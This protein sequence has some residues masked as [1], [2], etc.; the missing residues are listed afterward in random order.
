MAKKL[1]KEE[2]EEKIEQGFLRVRTVIEMLGAP[3]DYLT[4][5]LR[6]YMKKI[7]QNKDIILLKEKYAKPK[8]QEEMFSTFVEVDMLVRNASTLAFFCFDYMPASIEIT[9]PEKFTYNAVDFAAF[10][11]DML[12]RLHKLDMV[13]KNLNAKTENLEKNAGLLLRN[14]LLILMKEED[15]SL[16]EL[17]KGSGIPPDQLER[18]LEKLIREGWIKEKKDKYTRKK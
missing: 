8:K 11:N 12:A 4:K 16:K 13:I 17:S 3:K 15:K 18:F 9:D 10:F 1:A 2:I 7:D 14:N 5:T 6:M